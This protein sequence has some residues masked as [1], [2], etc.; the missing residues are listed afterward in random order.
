MLYLPN[1]GG[2]ALTLT[3]ADAGMDFEDVRITTADGVTLHGWF[4]EG[5][6]DRVLLFFHGNAGNISHRLASIGQFLG[7]GLSVMIIDYRGYGQS[8]GKTTEAG[9]Y[10]DAEAA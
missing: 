8:E 9:T 3:P 5:Q 7:L 1:V 10:R 2:R 6:S 4:I